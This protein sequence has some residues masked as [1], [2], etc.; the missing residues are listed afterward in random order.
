MPRV[1]VSSAAS[2]R[3]P[4]DIEIARLRALDFE[5]LRDPLANYI[6]TTTARLPC[7][8]IYCLQ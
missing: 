5:K 6:Q 2:D 1:K 3:K 4:I 7:P 8:A